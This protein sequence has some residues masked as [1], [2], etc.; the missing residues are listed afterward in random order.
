MM[1]LSVINLNSAINV[2]SDPWNVNNVCPKPEKL[3]V[4]SGQG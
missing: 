3:G 4:A 2:S 1:V